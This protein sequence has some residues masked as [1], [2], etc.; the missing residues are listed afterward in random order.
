MDTVRRVIE[1][2]NPTGLDALLP[3][4]DASVAPP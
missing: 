2:L 1:K 3:P 4:A